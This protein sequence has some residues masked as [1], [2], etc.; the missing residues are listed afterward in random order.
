LAT[1]N[2]GMRGIGPSHPAKFTAYWRHCRGL[3]GVTSH[4]ATARNR[5]F[6]NAFKL[7]QK[8]SGSVAP[9]QVIAS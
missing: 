3:S 5:K 2:L 6:V 1:Y 7:Q 4:K 8:C 9:S